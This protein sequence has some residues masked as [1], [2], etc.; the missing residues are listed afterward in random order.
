VGG[1]LSVPL[2]EAVSP[3]L[4]PSCRASPENSGATR[5]P[6]LS[7]LVP[8]IIRGEVVPSFSPF[9][10][11]EAISVL[12]EAGVGSENI[13][14]GE[15]SSDWLS[16]ANS[17][18]SGVLGAA[19][20]SHF[21]SAGGSLSAG[22]STKIGSSCNLSL[23]VFN[24]SL[25]P[26]P[27]GPYPS[28]REVGV[29]GVLTSKGSEAGVADVLTNGETG[30]GRRFSLRPVVGVYFGGTVDAVAGREG[31]EKREP[32]RIGILLAGC[33]DSCFEEPDFEEVSGSLETLGVGGLLAEGEGDPF[34]FLGAILAR[35]GHWI[36]TSLGLN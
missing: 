36:L 6:G 29:A 24:L 8:F 18:G 17:F 32:V 34:F 12:G 14:P 3:P 30:R 19:G 25:S 22:G 35:S 1:L 4:L 10:L 9:P 16:M 5:A 21:E 23:G 15:L 27:S 33:L 11:P 7:I 26:S 2:S 28:G 13:S 31:V 20:A